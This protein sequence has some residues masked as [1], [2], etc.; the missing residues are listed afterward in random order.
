M[1][2]P[3]HNIPS[4]LPARDKLNA[5]MADRAPLRAHEPS[6][7]TL[8]RTRRLVVYGGIG[9]P[10]DVERFDRIVASLKSLGDD[11]L[12]LQSGKPVGVFRTHS[13]APRADHQLQSGAALGEL[14][15]FNELDKG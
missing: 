11:R 7:R 1:D 10:P 4:P 14:G 5:F 13:D 9:P 6:I 2:N 15:A 3:R 8:P 12:H